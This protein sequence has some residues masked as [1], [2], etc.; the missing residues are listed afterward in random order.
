MKILASLTCCALAIVVAGSAF[1]QNSRGES[2][3][4]KPA[5]NVAERIAGIGRQTAN[6]RATPF[7]PFVMPKAIC[8]FN[9]PCAFIIGQP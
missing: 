5:L 3:T 4:D 8:C 1:A 7:R 2:F 6:W 9:T